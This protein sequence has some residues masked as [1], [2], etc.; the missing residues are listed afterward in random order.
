M[1]ILHPTTLGIIFLCLGIVFLA[2]VPYFDEFDKQYSRSWSLSHCI[3][4]GNNV[5]SCPLA[6]E[7]YRVY[8]QPFIYTGI[9]LCCIGI[10]LVSY[11]ILNNRMKLL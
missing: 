1:K 7:P 3:T 10:F 2:L 8:L 11:R 5:I 4:T 6:P 9:T